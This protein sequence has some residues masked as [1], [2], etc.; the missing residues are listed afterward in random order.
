M[1]ELIAK[2]NIKIEKGFLYYCK[3]D[4]EGNVAIYKINQR[5]RQ[6]NGYYPRVL[7]KQIEKRIKEINELNERLK[8]DR[9]N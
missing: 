5:G 3:G 7:K 8:N 4:E 2:T 1:G 9:N 6:R